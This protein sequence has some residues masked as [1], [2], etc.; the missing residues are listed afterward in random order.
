MEVA[1]K[2]LISTDAWRCGE[3]LAFVASGGGKSG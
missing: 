1:A 2:L 3:A